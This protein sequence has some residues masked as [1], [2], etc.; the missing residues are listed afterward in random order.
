MKKAWSKGLAILLTA[1]IGLTGCTSADGQDGASADSGSQPAADATAPG[2]FPIVKDK[3]TLKVLVTG[4]SLIEDMNTNAFT[5]WL[6][7][8]TNVHIEWEVAPASNPNEKLNLVLASGDYPDVIMNF[9]ISPTQQLIYGQQGVFMPLN[10]LIEKYGVET[11]KLF[12]RYPN[13]KKAISAPDGKIYSLPRINEN[14]HDLMNQ[15]MW[16]YTPWLDKL[17]LKMPTTTEEFYQVLK[18]FKTQD[19][20]GNGI[21]D[22]IPLAG[23]KEKAHQP[24]RFLM[25]AFQLDNETTSNRLIFKDGKIDVAYNKPGWK[26]GVAY[27]HKLYAEGLIAPEI[28]TQDR[29]QL[30]QMT[31]KQDAIVGTATANIIQDMTNIAG[32][33]NRWKDY[34]TVPPLK[35]PNG[36][37]ITPYN[38]YPFATGVFVIT[39]NCKNPE[40]A[41]RW[42]D[43]M[44]NEEFTLRSV[45]GE[46]G[47]DWDKAAPGEIG[48]NG[49]PAKWKKLMPFGIVQNKHWYQS[50]TTLQDLELRGSLYADPNIDAEKTLWD[51]TLKNYDS[52]KAK[53]EDMVP[54]IFFTEQQASELA[55]LEKT[56]N[57]YVEQM[58]TRFVTG[59]VSI[60]SQWDV[61]VKT[62]ENMNLKRMLEIYNEAYTQQY[63][64]G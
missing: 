30:K 61:Y 22:E 25:N 62:L 35:G 54:P 24:I 39:R 23:A 46:P 19:P 40:I 2:S 59:N 7:E 60:D 58:T 50:T 21:A 1:G 18:A 55:D 27:M 49:K 16:I 28:Y 31:E 11:K 56:V 20:N 32:K 45:H 29:A 10:E 53:V 26:E 47:V 48:V 8:K 17:G 37:Q 57:D 15:K 5:K 6:E 44:Y 42:A 43:A 36:L 33:L 9:G 64:K 63:K 34:K 3:V 52:Y 4:N 13:I 12:E 38:P 51:E 41:L 14:Y